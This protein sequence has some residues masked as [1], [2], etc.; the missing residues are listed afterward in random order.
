MAIYRDDDLHY[1]AIS[2]SGANNARIDVKYIQYD[3]IENPED[4]ERTATRAAEDGR[5]G[6]VI[7]ASSPKCDGSPKNKASQGNYP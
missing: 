6:K 2:K 4:H 1:N 7:L 5:S 3:E